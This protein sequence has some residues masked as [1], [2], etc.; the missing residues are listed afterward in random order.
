MFLNIGKV[1]KG[2]ELFD[3]PHQIEPMSTKEIMK[4][5]PSFAKIFDGQGKENTL[6]FY[7]KKNKIT[8]VYEFIDEEAE[9]EVAELMDVKIKTFV[10]ENEDEIENKKLSDEQI[11][12]FKSQLKDVQNALSEHYKK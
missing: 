1:C 4:K 7:Y 6:L 10:M 11:Q 3:V 5:F 9:E 8:D 12:D 2:K